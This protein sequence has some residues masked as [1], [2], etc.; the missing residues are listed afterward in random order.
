M[1]TMHAGRALGNLEQHRHVLQVAR[2]GSRSIAAQLLR[3]IPTYTTQDVVL[4]IPKTEASVLQQARVM[5][6]L[7]PQQ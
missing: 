3:L 2:R 1:T 4:D 6:S 5:S 7:T